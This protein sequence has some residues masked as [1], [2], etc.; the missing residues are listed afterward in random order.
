VDRTSLQ[1][2]RE[3]L[4]DHA[5][6]KHALLALER[7]E[8]DAASA[9]LVIDALE[10]GLCEPWLAA[11]LLGAIGHP[12]GYATALA[13]LRS[14]PDVRAKPWAGPALTKIRGDAALADLEAVL[15]DASLHRGTREGAAYGLIEIADR[16]ALDVLEAALDAERI[17]RSTAGFVLGERP[18]EAALLLEWLRGPRAR[19]RATAIWALFYRSAGLDPAIPDELRGALF[20]ELDR[21]DLPLTAEQERMLRERY[22]RPG[23]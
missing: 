1:L 8:P 18:L 7:L 22:A 20:V 15:E 10:R 14:S 4:S 16:R 6:W 5:R 12:D 23:A 17:R 3:A 13:L 21:G 19:R 9:R 2:A 11:A